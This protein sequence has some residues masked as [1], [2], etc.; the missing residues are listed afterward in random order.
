MKI[1]IGVCIAFLSCLT[2]GEDIKMSIMSGYGNTLPNSASF[3]PVI[4]TVKN[5]GL[6]LIKGELRLSRGGLFSAASGR[7][8]HR[9]VVLPG[10]SNKVFTFYVLLSNSRTVISAS[11]VADGQVFT[12]EQS[13]QARLSNHPIWI[14]WKKDI[15]KNKYY[16]ETYYAVANTPLI[17]FPRTPIALS[18]VAVMFVAEPQNFEV[19]EEQTA[20]LQKWISHGG[21][22][23]FV[24]TS[25]LEALI[26]RRLPFL[27]VE[28]SSDSLLPAVTTLNCGRVVCFSQS[29]DHPYIQKLHSNTTFVKKTLQ[30]SE[31]VYREAYHSDLQRYMSRELSGEIQFAWMILLLIAYLICI[32]PVDYFITKKFKNRMLTWWIY[33]FS[34]VL[35]SFFAYIKGYVLKSG[36][37]KIHCLNYIDVYDN[38]EA[39]GSTVFGVYST[40]NANYTLRNT[41]QNGY[42]LP[43]NS[44]FTYDE[45]TF[46]QENNRLVSRIPI[47]SSKNY[48]G[49]W[50]KTYPM[51]TQKIA[52]DAN[53]RFDINIPQGFHVTDGYI[54]M[55]GELKR[56]L[57][58]GETWYVDAVSRNSNSEAKKLLLGYSS[59]LKSS[60]YQYKVN[61]KD[62]EKMLDVT[63]N[64]KNGMAVVLFCD[65]DNHVQIVGEDPIRNEQS[66]LRYVVPALR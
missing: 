53:K 36:P 32:G 7:S 8:Y 10:K 40:R 49:V 5:E 15:K 20:I 61:I 65:T 34:I 13:F 29:K 56:V 59:P 24:G 12:H 33:I 47:Y 38:G 48:I 11:L 27:Q 21:S 4:V 46:D 30:Y 17:A 62:V 16:D 63:R 45:E 42:F 60:F 57:T 3:E 23:I 19:D 2:F 37:M 18:N 51:R 43:L 41:S 14:N 44:D 25:G 52:F 64:L 31:S 6:K 28:F 55:D 66:V 35:F 58:V 22:L 50:Q 39:I 9:E 54:M 26:Q 1:F